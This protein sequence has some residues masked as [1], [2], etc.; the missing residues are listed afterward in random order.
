MWTVTLSRLY[1]NYICGFHTHGVWRVDYILCKGLDHPQIL[2]STGVLETTHMDIEGKGK[3][4]VAQLCPT[5]CD[6]MDYTGH[7]ILQARI[8][9]WVAFPFSRASSQTRDRT[10][11]SN[12]AGRFFTSWHKGNPR[13]LEWVAYPFSR[14]LP[15]PGIKPGSLALKADSFP[16]ELQG[17]RPPPPIYTSPIHDYYSKF[18]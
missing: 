4:K 18:I 17:S 11:I 6:P 15:D 10:Q 5:L 14:D 8:L 9:E 12:T 3:G 1:K 2:A 7:G 16:S 13:I